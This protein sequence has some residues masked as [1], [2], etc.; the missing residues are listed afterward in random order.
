MNEPVWLKKSFVLAI[1]E[2][3]LAEFGGASGVRDI[4]LLEATLERPIT[5]Y[6]YGMKDRYLLAAQYAVGIIQ[7]HPFFD[8]NK[9]TGFL[10]AAA[11]LELNGSMFKATEADV[12]LKTLSL[13]VGEMTE[14]DYALW[15][16]AET[17]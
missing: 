17:K 7:G 10:C 2:S 9:R 14:K 15:L 16:E 1:H 6:G 5:S 11:F 13:T 3:I 12:V 4:A 8:G